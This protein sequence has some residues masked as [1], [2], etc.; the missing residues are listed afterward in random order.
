MTICHLH[1]AEIPQLLPLMWRPLLLMLPKARGFYF[2]S[3]NRNC[4]ALMLVHIAFHCFEVSW[5]C[6][7]STKPGSH[8]SKLD[9]R[10]GWE[11]RFWLI[12]REGRTR[13]G[14][15]ALNAAECLR[16][17]GVC[18]RVGAQSMTGV[19]RMWSAWML[20]AILRS[21]SLKWWP[22]VGAQDC[23]LRSVRITLSCHSSDPSW[24]FR[25]TLHI[26]LLGGGQYLLVFSGLTG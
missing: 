10:K 19:H 20:S 12:S 8:I 9:A 1:R 26:M 21:Q 11:M 7:R 25:E 17:V 23:W 16:S 22:G 15:I 6:V 3:H 4:G 5:E 2:L 24:V 18:L 14:E 13:K